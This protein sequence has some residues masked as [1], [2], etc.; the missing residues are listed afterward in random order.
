MN[1]PDSIPIP[2][3]VPPIIETVA[4][5]GRCDGASSECDVTTQ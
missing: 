2:C 5:A 3:D 4:A 1:P